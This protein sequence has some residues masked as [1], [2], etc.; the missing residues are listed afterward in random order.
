MK[1]TRHEAAAN[2]DY[3]EECK[4]QE[5]R[6]AKEREKENGI[7]IV[8]AFLTGSLPPMSRLP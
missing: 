6:K 8:G 5:E 1:W 4:E 3:E 2:S 7:R